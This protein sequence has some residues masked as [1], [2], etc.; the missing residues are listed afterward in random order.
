MGSKKELSQAERSLIVQ[1]HSEG[2]SYRQIAKKYCVSLSAISRA[3]QKSKEGNL[4]SKSRSGRPRA[5]SSRD[6]SFI[7][8]EIGNDPFSSSK[9]ISSKMMQSCGKSYSASSI[10][11][12]LMRKGLK[13]YASK[14]KS[15]ITKNMAK[16]R[17]QWCRKYE[18]ESVDFWKN[19]IFSDESKISV[20]E[21]ALFL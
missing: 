17:L 9:K 11:K 20:N 19:V 4:S 13:S 21:N 10:R 2:H 5:I 1:E 18:N 7:M 15:L 12:L 8:R 3:I 14:K 6:E 16:K